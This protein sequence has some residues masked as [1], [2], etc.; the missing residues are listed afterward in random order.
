MWFSFSYMIALARAY[1]TMLDKNGESG[2][3]CLVPYLRGNA[4]S[5][6]PLCMMLAVFLL[7]VA[8]IMLRYAHFLEFYH[9]RMENFV[10]K[11]SASIEMSMIFILQFVNVSP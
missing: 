8:F 1:N 4:F 9:K 2:H 5:F 11:C 3:P 7:Y 10:K 6:S